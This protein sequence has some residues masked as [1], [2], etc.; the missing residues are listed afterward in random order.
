MKLMIASDIHGS[1][2]Y[3]RMLTEAFEKEN[4]DKLLILGDILYH[5]PRNDLPEE[6]APKKVIELLNPLKE[7]LLCV[8][9]NCD[10]E[11]DQMVLDFPVLAEYCILWLDN[12]TIFATHG[13]K[14]NEQTLPPLC[15]GD[16]L[17]NGHTH[18]PAYRE[19]NGIIYINPG[20][21]SIP[22]ENSKHQYM[23]L[24]NNK[25]TWKELNGSILREETV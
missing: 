19:T 1:A 23:I 24:E 16:I 9:G 20:S 14:F 6:Y 12:R 17:L 8:R 13:H 15:K 21:V 25:F 4:P 2:K 11:V 10:T 3:C 18:I 22:K 7:K 5:G